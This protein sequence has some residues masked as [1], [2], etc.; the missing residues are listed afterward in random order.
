MWRSIKNFKASYSYPL[1]QPVK[2]V[3][4]RWSRTGLAAWLM[5][6]Y[7]KQVNQ[8]DLVITERII[9]LPTLQ[10]WLGRIFLQ[11]QGEVL[12]IGHVASDASLALANL[13]YQVTA[14]D[15]RP[16]PFV[17]QNLNSLEGDFLK[18]D[19]NKK[20]DAVFSLSTIEHFGFSARYGGV[21]EPNNNLDQQAFAKISSLLKPDGH[22]IISVP[23]AKTHVDGIW[24]RVYTQ[25][26]LESKL[27]KYFNISESRFYRRDNN[28]WLPVTN[29]KNDPA[30]PHDGVALFLLSK[31]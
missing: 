16:Y 30:S 24:F 6:K 10:Q 23:Y 20:F 28:Q 17:H 29:P 13:G 25:Q 15:L 18:Y 19:F 1:E 4:R 7:G 11:P 3:L 12:E 22:A 27:G 9:E 26:D 2:V 31:K 21:D 14:I 8:S 5:Q